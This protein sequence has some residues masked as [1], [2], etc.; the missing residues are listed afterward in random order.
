M[1]SKLWPI[2]LLVGV[3][4]LVLLTGCAGPTASQP[5]VPTAST[6]VRVTPSASAGPDSNPITA[7][8][9]TFTLNFALSGRITGH[10]TKAG[11]D[12]SLC[13]RPNARVEAVF[14]GDVNGDAVGVQVII[15]PVAAGSAHAVIVV[16]PP[17]GKFSPPPPGPLGANVFAWS[18]YQ[19]SAV[20]DPDGVSAFIQGDLAYGGG[21]VEEHISGSWNCQPAP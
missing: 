16:S 9:A 1:S 17:N 14:K 12:G 6:S 13:Q 8:N 21:P 10:M 20:V 15:D 19:G 2:R 4:P 7:S 5:G 18:T 11:A 3:A